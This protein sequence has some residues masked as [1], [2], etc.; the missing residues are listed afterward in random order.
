[1]VS[2]AVALATV[3]KTKWKYRFHK[4]LLTSQFHRGSGLQRRAAAAL[5]SERLMQGVNRC[6]ISFCGAVFF[7]LL[8]PDLMISIHA[9]A[10]LHVGKAEAWHKR[11][12]PDHPISSRFNMLV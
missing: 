5:N 9:I 7:L 10:A 2:A 6:Q 11:V 3:F 12:A 1:M 4:N 8:F